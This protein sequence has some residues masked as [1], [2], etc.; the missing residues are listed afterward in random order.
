MGLRLQRKQHSVGKGWVVA[1]RRDRGEFRHDATL[2]EET[3]GDTDECG[4]ADQGFQVEAFRYELVILAAEPVLDKSGQGRI[5]IECRFAAKGDF[6]SVTMAI[7]G[8]ECEHEF[9]LVR[10]RLALCMRVWPRAGANKFEVA[11]IPSG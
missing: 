5:R 3:L 6:E 1:D 11:L 4:M 9:N 10:L 8:I 2:G 7:V